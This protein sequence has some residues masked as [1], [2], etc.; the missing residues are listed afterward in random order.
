MQF[1]FLH[2]VYLRLVLCYST[3]HTFVLKSI[4]SHPAALL[5]GGRFSRR[6]TAGWRSWLHFFIGGMILRPSH[7]RAVLSLSL[8]LIL[9]WY[10]FWNKPFFS[11]L[12][13]SWGLWIKQREM[14]QWVWLIDHSA[15]IMEVDKQWPDLQKL[16]IQ[17]HRGSL[18]FLM[19]VVFASAWTSLNYVAWL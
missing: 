11:L 14:I 12:S 9:K 3:I 17:Q 8:S 5:S 19:A 18:T 15:V 10:G 7:F 16:F 1:A 13:G 2:S 4:F 6:K